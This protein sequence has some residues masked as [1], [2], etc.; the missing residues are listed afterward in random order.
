MTFR[1]L[2]SALPLILQPPPMINILG[3]AIL[4]EM[5]HADLWHQGIFMTSCLLPKQPEPQFSHLTNGN[6]LLLLQEQTH[7][8]YSKRGKKTLG[9]KGG[10]ALTLGHFAKRTNQ[11]RL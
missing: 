2:F 5:A 6:D 3:F 4:Q 7:S 8:G 9:N 1:D 11:V 10:M